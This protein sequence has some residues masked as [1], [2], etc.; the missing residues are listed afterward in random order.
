MLPEPDPVL[1]SRI[2]ICNCRPGDCIRSSR[3]ARVTFDG[4]GAD[5]LAAL[6]NDTYVPVDLMLVGETA[7]VP[8]PA[9]VFLLASGTFCMFTLRR[10]AT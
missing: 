8:L 7:V 1:A 4:L 2:A 5:P 10:R 9:G 3:I 6:T